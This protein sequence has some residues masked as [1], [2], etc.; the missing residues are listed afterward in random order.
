MLTHC[1]LAQV[2]DPTR[3]VG[4]LADEGGHVAVHHEGD[5]VLGER[6]LVV[7]AVVGVAGVDGLPIPGRAWKSA[8][9]FFNIN[10]L[11]FGHMSNLIP[12]NVTALAI[13][14]LISLTA[15]LQDR[16][17]KPSFLKKAMTLFSSLSFHVVSTCA[18]WG[19][20]KKGFL[21]PN[22]SERN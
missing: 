12:T 21:L 19:D 3:Q 8:R 18:L 6:G 20:S 10:V 15:D 9:F 1:V 14:D 7:R 5:G 17:E 11:F 16:K 2:L 4:G 13:F 22:Y